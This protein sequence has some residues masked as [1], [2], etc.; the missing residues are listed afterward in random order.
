MINAIKQLVAAFLANPK[1]DG[2]DFVDC[3][4]L[5]VAR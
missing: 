4:T 1:T 5:T 3:T 2:R